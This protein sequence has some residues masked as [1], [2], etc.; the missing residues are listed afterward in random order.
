MVQN[1][2]EDEPRQASLKACGIVLIITA[3]SLRLIP[4]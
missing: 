3:A 2:V 1:G 4:D